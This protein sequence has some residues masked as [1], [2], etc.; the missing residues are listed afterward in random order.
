MRHGLSN[1]RQRGRGSNNQN[2]GGGGGNRPQN[3]RTQVFDSN[4]PDVRIRGTAHQVT[5]KYLLLSKDAA[6]AGDRVLAESYLQHAEHYQ[7][8]INSWEAENPNRNTF[9]PMDEPVDGNTAS[10]NRPVDQPVGEDNLGLPASILG[11]S[12]KASGEE[13]GVERTGFSRQAT[14]EDA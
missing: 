12:P 9:R 11:G 7:R 4:G 14:T 5:E 3:Q 8:I 10:V 6:S 13:A 2:R 1:R